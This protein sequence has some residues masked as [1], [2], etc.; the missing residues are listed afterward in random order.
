[1]GE[2]R[3]KRYIG[4]DFGTSNSV[5]RYKDYSSDNNSADTEAVLSPLPVSIAHS[6]MVRSLILERGNGTREYGQQA[7]LLRSNGTLHRNFKMALTSDKE[8]DRAEAERLMCLF[9]GYLRGGCNSYLP[10][11]K[12]GDSEHTF[13]SYPAKWS[14]RA[15]TAV[16][17]AAKNAG[18]RNVSSLDEPNSALHCCLQHKPSNK[19]MT[20]FEELQQEGVLTKERPLNVMLLDLGAGTTD[21]VLSR[22]IPHDGQV[23]NLVTWPSFTSKDTFG[24]REVDHFLM[25]RVKGYLESVGMKV[26]EKN[27]AKIEESCKEWKEHSLSGDLAQHRRSQQVPIYLDQIMDVLELS[28]TSPF[29]GFD[30]SELARELGAYLDTFPRL[31]NGAIREAIKLGPE[32]GISSSADIDLVILTGGHSRWYF[33]R[34]MLT[35]QMLAPGGERIDLPQLFGNSKR[36]LQMENPEQTV[37]IGLAYQGR[38]LKLRSV[39]SN[40]CWLSIRCGLSWSLIN[41]QIAKQHTLLPY[42]ASWSGSGT[43]SYES[44]QY[45]PIGCQ[46]Q[47]GE[48]NSTAVSYWERRTLDQGAFGHAVDKAI[49]FVREI[50]FSGQKHEELEWTGTYDIAVEINETQRGTIRASFTYLG[51]TVTVSF[52]I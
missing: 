43:F 14:S 2:A 46:L 16:E 3:I 23:L 24:G 42:R 39:M 27:E 30:R 25:R 6:D 48:E 29:P 38:P 28:D 11:L 10:A 17:Q 15:R 1:M 12:P 44:S 33:V 26:P 47:I 45:I 21:I 49:S 20:C 35:G 7:E 13:V 34:E 9:F 52:I 32:T 41:L 19:T 8:E 18:F 4:I 40:N 37:A 51:E 5:V 31:V 50:M 36:L 22:F